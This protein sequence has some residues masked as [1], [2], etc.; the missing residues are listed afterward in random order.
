M[1]GFID[2]DKSHL[3]ERDAAAIATD[4]GEWRRSIQ[5][6]RLAPTL[7][8]DF[9][10]PRYLG[11]QRAGYCSSD[12]RKLMKSPTWPGSSLNSGMLGWPVTIPSPS[13]SSSDSTGYRS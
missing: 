5:L 8:R 4:K 3:P 13:A 11:N 6:L 9:L 7:R 12:F 1:T 2:G 10:L